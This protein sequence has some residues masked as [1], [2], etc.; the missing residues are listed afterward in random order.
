MS[1]PT[2]SISEAS[3]RLL[4]ELA[5]RTG[6]PVT[7][8]LDEALDAYRRA[9]FFDRVNA[10]YAELRADPE[11]WA[12]HAAERQQWDATLTDGLD[13][14]DRWTNDGRSRTPE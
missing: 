6:R 8:V 11:A 4:K 1:A 12:E 14:D 2:V 5:E 3:H 7:E 10:G 9:L 13:A